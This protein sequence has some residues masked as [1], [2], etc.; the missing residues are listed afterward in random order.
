MATRFLFTT[1]K[2]A[3]STRSR[4]LFFLRHLP[5]AAISAGVRLHNQAVSGLVRGYA[6]QQISSSIDNPTPNWFSCPPETPFFDGCDF[7]HWL[8]V[9][10]QPAGNPSR[11]QIIHRYIKTLAKVVGS[12]E[13]ARKR[14][15]SVSTRHYYAFGALVSED[16]H[17]RLADLEG[18]MFVLPDSYVDMKTRDYGGE[19]FINGQAVPYDPKYHEE[20]VRNQAAIQARLDKARECALSKGFVK[21]GTGTPVTEQNQPA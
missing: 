13:E 7:E 21:W 14:I 4:N 8:V 12:E 20:F 6:T 5:L 18:V 9:M 3:I 11:D 10:R 1:A 17:Q 2:Q 15:Y 16:L 19:P